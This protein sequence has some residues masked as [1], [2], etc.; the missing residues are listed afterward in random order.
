MLEMKQL[1]FMLAIAVLIDATLVR[2]LL[3]PAL[4]RLMGRWN[5]WMPGWLGARRRA[6]LQV[7]VSPLPTPAA[8][9]PE[10]TV[11]IQSP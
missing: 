11:G 9:E 5:W 2:L 7:N 1:G 3:V 4:M 6:G 8:A 10:P